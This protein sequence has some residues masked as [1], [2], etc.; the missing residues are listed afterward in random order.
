[1][2][3]KITLYVNEEYDNQVTMDETLSSEI[4]SFS[5]ITWRYLIE[6]IIE[7][8]LPDDEVDEYLDMNYGISADQLDERLDRINIDSYYSKIAF[9]IDNQV[10]SEACA[11]DFLR[12]L[13]IFPTDKDGNGDMNGVELV[14]TT[15]NG[16]KKIVYIQ[17]MKSAN[18][19]KRECKKKGV[20]INI[21]FI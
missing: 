20:V 13:E 7:D 14:Q 16:P 4:D 1:M 2:A 21:E 6:N 15:A 8:C 12:S 9:H 5:D 18:W 3:D 17:D 11:F 10:G 19:L